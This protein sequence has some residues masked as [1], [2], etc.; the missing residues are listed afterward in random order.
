MKASGIRVNIVTISISTSSNSQI[1]FIFRDFLHD[2]EKS[3]K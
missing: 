2:I 1:G 3:K